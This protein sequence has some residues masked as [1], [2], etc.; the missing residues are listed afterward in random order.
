MKYPHPEELRELS[1][2]ERLQLIGDL[3]D[4]LSGDPESLPVTEEH[5]RELDRRL[6]E[7]ERASD[8]GVTWS[9]LQ[10]RLRQK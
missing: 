10:R 7:F 2:G 6:E 3:W 5:R 4:S 9:E 8:A 1:P